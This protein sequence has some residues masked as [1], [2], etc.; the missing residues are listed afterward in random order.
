[1]TLADW[2]AE[3]PEASAKPGPGKALVDGAPG[4]RAHPLSYAAL[5]AQRREQL[6]RAHG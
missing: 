5:L 1:M 2:L 3:A 6:D 4:S